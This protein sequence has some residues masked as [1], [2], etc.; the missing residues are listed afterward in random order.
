MTLYATIVAVCLTLFIRSWWDK[1]HPRAAMT[2]LGVDLSAEAIIVIIGGAFAMAFCGLHLPKRLDYYWVPAL[3]MAAILSY[4]VC[5]DYM[6]VHK[7]TYLYPNTQGSSTSIGYDPPSW[8][9][10]VAP[11]VLGMTVLYLVLSLVSSLINSPACKTVG[12]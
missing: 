8:K 6:K 4:I 3:T 12:G 9:F 10:S 11:A 1:L 5:L 7:P 2:A